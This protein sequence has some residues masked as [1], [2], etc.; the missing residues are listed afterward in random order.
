[1]VLSALLGLALS[2]SP[3]P[4]ETKVVSASLF[5]NGYAVVVR[6]A[7]IS[8]SGEL[9]VGD[10]P[11]AVLGTLWITASS[12]VKLREVV[13]TTQKTV[14]DRNA[15]SLDEILAANVGK[16]LSLVTSDK[17]LLQ[18]KLLSATGS[19][20][21][22][23]RQEG[24]K[25]AG[26]IAIQKGLVLQVAAHGGDLVWK[27]KQEEQSRV[28]KLK[29]D[30]ASRGSL[31]IVSLERGLTWAPGYA[32][33]ISDPKKLKLTA[34]ATIMNDLEDLSGIEVKLVTGFPNIPFIQ[35]WDPL[36]TQENLHQWADKLMQLGTPDAMRR[37]AGMGGQMAQN[38]A[39]SR[40]GAF[41]EAFDPSTLQGIQAEDLFFYRQPGVALNK[42]DR[43][44]YVLLGFDADYEHVY[45]WEI[46]DQIRDDRYYNPNP[47]EVVP[48][49][50]WH[51]I[52]FKNVSKQ[53]LTTASA[54]TIKDGEILGQDMLK[55]TS[56]GAE[57]C[58]KIT[59]ALDVRAES[60][61]EETAR[62]RES[63]KLRSGYYDLVTL[64]GV[65]R[66]TNRK[67]ETVK[68]S[69]TKY[70]TGEVKTAEGKPT[71]TTQAKGLRAVNPKQKLEWTVDVKPG[72]KVELNYSYTVYITG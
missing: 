44:Y 1:M 17:G 33:D 25:S 46:Q 52:R 45:E 53:P 7:P 39:Y 29:A 37:Q 63:L 31:Y 8:G 41:D 61:E 55:Y 20:L 14:K 64:K 58:V 71:I 68:L 70:L 62:E 27:V 36:T 11:Q 34:K 40:T 43:G 72:A 2:S 57:S 51:S 3:A 26:T 19:I 56:V 23:D 6:E 32:L 28:L 59:K 4:V 69:I 30:T 16:D 48:D 65:L 60:T 50:V 18:G 12:G 66:I 67:T 42:G 54:V 47:S 22:V 15:H 49:D 13:V 10:L 5:K 38:M 21:V 24:G 35:M 9:V